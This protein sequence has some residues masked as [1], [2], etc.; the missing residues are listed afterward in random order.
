NE[1]SFHLRSKS[2]FIT[3]RHKTIEVAPLDFQEYL[4]FKNISISKKEGYLLEKYF[5]EYLYTGGIPE[6]VLRGEIEY[7]KELVDDIIMKDIAAQH[8]VRSIALLKDFF[9]LLMERVGKVFSINK[10]ANILKISPDTA[11][12]YLELFNSSYLIH[13]LPRAGKTNEV[14]LSAKKIYAADLGIKTLFTGFKDKGNLFENYVYL[15]IKDRNPAY[16]YKDGTEI[17]FLTEDKTLIE[18]KY[19]SELTKAQSKLFS[20]FK[21]KDKI[22]IKS[23]ND[24]KKIEID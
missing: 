7:L 12:R 10:L 9:L 20:E 15:K 11:K 5:L 2:S 16:V 6:F 1:L 23:Y 21:S 4:L 19:N 24:L 18:V 3:G 22:I 17:D 8:N 14:I 13:L